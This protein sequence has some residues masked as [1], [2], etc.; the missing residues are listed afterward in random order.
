[1]K[2]CLLGRASD[3]KALRRLVDAG[4]ELK[5]SMSGFEALRLLVEAVRVLEENSRVLLAAM[6]VLYIEA[7]RLLV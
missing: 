5:E 4:R 1:M 7:V 6:K 2:E 3:V